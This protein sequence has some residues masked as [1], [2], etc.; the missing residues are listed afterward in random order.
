MLDG[1]NQH[2]YNLLRGLDLTVANLMIGDYEM[3]LLSIARTMPNNVTSI[4]NTMA[5]ISHQYLLL[6]MQK[7]IFVVLLLTLKNQLIQ[8]H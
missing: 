1:F 4:I 3:G 7:M 8:W 2:Q 6:F 5:P